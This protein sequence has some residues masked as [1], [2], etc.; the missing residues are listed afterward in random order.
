MKL[1]YTYEG[2][3]NIKKIL[4]IL[5]C[6]SAFVII[7]IC[8]LCLI[9]V[10]DG[11]NLKDF[12]G[13]MATAFSFFLVAPGIIVLGFWGNG[14][15]KKMDEECVKKGVKVK[16]KILH[17]NPNCVWNSKIP[18]HGLDIFVKG[19]IYTARYIACNEAYKTLEKYLEN[20]RYGGVEIDVY[21]YNNKIYADL[22]AVDIDNILSK[23][24]IKHN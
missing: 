5:L 4:K 13:D 12:W 11:H 6:I 1:E 10:K 24:V 8:C 18:A 21:V 20:N 3:K 2:N 16:G 14:M 23:M 7:A 22:S 19:R 15:Q 17:T 9:A